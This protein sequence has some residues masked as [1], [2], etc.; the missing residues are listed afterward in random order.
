MSHL[1]FRDYFAGQVMV[2]VVSMPGVDVAVMVP[3]WASMACLTMERPR[4]V[5]LTWF[6][7]WCFWT[8]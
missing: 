2:K 7:E 8:R 1:N 6:W 3:P 4:P 5:P